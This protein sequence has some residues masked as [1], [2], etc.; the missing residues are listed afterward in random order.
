MRRGSP[1]EASVRS[2][3]ETR[4]QRLDADLRGDPHM[5]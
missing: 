4:K 5:Y 1:N 3:L 2:D